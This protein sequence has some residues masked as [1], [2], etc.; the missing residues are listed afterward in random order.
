MNMLWDKKKAMQT[1]IAKR[2]DGG[3]P[4][5]VGPAPMK[6]EVV[7]TEDGEIDGR[8]MAAQDVMA[9]FHEK[10]SEKLMR[11]L[12]DFMDLHLAQPEKQDPRED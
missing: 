6:N 10:S 8:H 11:S 7:K 9:A 5:E 1:M 12:A 4:M 3:G 2:R